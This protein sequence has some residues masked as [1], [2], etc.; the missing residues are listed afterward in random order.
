MCGL[1]FIFADSGI[2]SVGDSIRGSSDSMSNG[3]SNGASAA[4]AESSQEVQVSASAITATADPPKPVNPQLSN[5]LVSIEQQVFGGKIQ[6]TYECCQCH[7]VSIHTEFF[8]DLLLPFPAEVKTDSVE[9]AALKKGLTMQVKISKDQF[10]VYFDQ[11]THAC[12][13]ICM[14]VH[15][16]TWL[17]TMKNI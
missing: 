17:K 12:A 5:P 9:E 4:E 13:C 6:T 14:L 11:Q 15:A 8:N 2:Q 1:I 16:F 10:V 3:P 7:T